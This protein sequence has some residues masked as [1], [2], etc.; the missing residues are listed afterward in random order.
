[1][2]SLKVC[3]RIYE[4]VHDGALET[5]LHT[6]PMAANRIQL[7]H[8]AVGGLV[9]PTHLQCSDLCDRLSL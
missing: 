3:E 6:N 4:D 2:I 7:Q 8:E 9:L 1:M 5:A